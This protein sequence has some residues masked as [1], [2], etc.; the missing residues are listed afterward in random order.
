MKKFLVVTGAR[1]LQETEL[2]ASEPCSCCIQCLDQS[3][4]VWKFG[5]CYFEWKLSG[6]K[7]KSQYFPLENNYN[8]DGH[9]PLLS[10]ALQ[11]FTVTREHLLPPDTR[12]G[13]HQQPCPT[14]ALAGRRH[15][16]IELTVDKVYVSP[17]L[18]QHRMDTF[19]LANSRRASHV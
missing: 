12:A 14:N 11:C 6:W 15:L 4:S 1:R 3:E 8:K 5:D 17:S 16:D 2:E 9:F 19:P 18:A 13:P 10:L 7:S